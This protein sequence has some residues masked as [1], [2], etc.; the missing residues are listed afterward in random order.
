MQV[1]GHAGAVV[2]PGL[3]ATGAVDVRVAS[4]FHLGVQG[5][6]FSDNDNG[7]PFGGARASYRIEATRMIRVVPSFGIAHV[8]VLDMD[9]DESKT[10]NQAPVSFT[11][12]LELA[13]ELGHFLVGCDLQVMPT[14]VT[15]HSIYTPAAQSNDKTLWLMPASLFAGATF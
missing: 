15:T 6:F 13:L 14:R 4:G 2:S 9:I 11:G 8:Q 5:G 1:V 12:G 10:A 7:Y 3:G